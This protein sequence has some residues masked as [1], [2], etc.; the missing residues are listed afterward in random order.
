MKLDEA[1]KLFPDM[2]FVEPTEDDEA[3][4]EV[5]FLRRPTP[6]EE[7]DESESVSSDKTFERVPLRAI[8]FQRPFER[9]GKAWVA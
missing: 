8:R 3:S 9:E 2:H 6:S 1:K 5:A 4:V 7:A